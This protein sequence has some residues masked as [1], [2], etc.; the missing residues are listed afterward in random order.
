MNCA[1]RGLWGCR[2][3][4]GGTTRQ[5]RFLGQ[6]LNSCARCLHDKRDATRKSAHAY[7]R[8]ALRVPDAFGTFSQRQLLPDLRTVSTT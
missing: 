6:A 2:R 3:V 8:A 4:T 5:V 7:T 1:R